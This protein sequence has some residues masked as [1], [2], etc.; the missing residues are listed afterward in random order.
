[1]AMKIIHHLFPMSRQ[2]R[3]YLYVVGLNDGRI[4]IGQTIDPR[5]R[6]NCHRLQLGLAWCHLFPHGSR[7]YVNVA[8]PTGI[9]A[10]AAIGTRIGRTEQFHGIDKATAIRTL[11]EVV[12]AAQ[13]DERKWRATE[14]FRA[15]EA[16]AWKAF[17]AQYITEAA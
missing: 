8:E 10:L 1:M 14:E 15:K 5:G 6:M 11:R 12:A 9:K 16:R 17:Q 13:A 7:Y 3:F 2:G 4:K